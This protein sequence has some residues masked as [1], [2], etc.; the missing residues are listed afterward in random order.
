LDDGISVCLRDITEQKKAQEEIRFLAFYDKLTGLPNR[1]LLQ[2]RLGQAI[3]RCRRDNHRGAVL[4]MDLDRFKHINDS[5][6]H[7]TGDRVLQEVARRL[8]TCIREGDTVARLGGDEF[9]ILLDSIDHPEHVHWIIDRIRNALAQDLLQSG[10]QL[11]LTAS[12]GISLIPDDGGTVEDLLKTADTAMYYSKKRGGNAYHFY[13]PHMNARTQSLLVLEGNLRKSFQNKEFTVVFQPQHDLRTLALLGF[14]A[15]LRWSHPDL[16]VVPP[17]EFIPVAEET[18]LILPLGE[19]VLESACRQGRSW[20]EQHGQCLRMAV[21]VS[22]RQFWQGD[23][24]ATVSRVLA[25]TGFPPAQLELELTES[26]V[27]NDVDQAIRT[28]HNLADMGVRLSIDDF[29]TG[30]S[31]LYTLQ[32]FPIHALKIDQSFV[33]DVT[34]NPNDQAISKAIIGLAHSLKLEV[35]AEG[36]ERPD[37]LSCLLGMG[38]ETGQGFLFSAPI[39][40]QDAKAAFLG[41]SG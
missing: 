34:T 4:F 5:L 32:K 33:K 12:I 19:W 27:M 14:E 38:C 17:S 35:I 20:M 21:N 29:G 41:R 18:G 28:M 36:I 6:G 24:V 10:V 7:D 15:L 9:I 26:M 1:T 8:K 25:A 40:A 3:S 16:G 23:L 11:S 39:T 37:Q 30:Y 13:H 22:G 31:S 2:D